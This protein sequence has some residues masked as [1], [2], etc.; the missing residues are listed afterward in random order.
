[1]PN[2]M[3]LPS[4]TSNNSNYESLDLAV[5]KIDLI[6]RQSING[7]IVIF[8]NAAA[9]LYISWNNVSHA[10]SI[11]WVSV[12]FTS[13]LIRLSMLYRWN[14]VKPTLRHMDETHFWHRTM[15]GLLLISGLC[16][17]AVGLVAPFGS[18][19]QQI[20]TA[21]LVCSMSAGAMITYVSSRVAM[22]C[23]VAPAMLGWG[24]GYVTS[25]QPHHLLVGMLVMVYC[26]LMIVMGKNLNQAI[27]KLLTLD[28]K[29]QKNEEHLRMS[30]ASSDALTW[31]WDMTTDSLHC[32]GNA[33]LFPLG[34]QQLKT[35]LKENRSATPELYTEAIFTDS[36]GSARHVALKGRF[37]RN[38][39]N[40]PYRAT[41]IAWDI[42]T[43]RN[44]E[45][46][47]R[48]R[49]LHEAANNAKSVLLANASHEIRTPLAAILGFADTLL[50]NPHL[51]DQS[52]RDVQSIHRQGNF[53]ASLVNDLLDLS[54]IETN[55]LYIQKAPMN[56]AR[57]LEDSLSVIRSALEDQKHDIQIYYES[58]IPEIIES[59]SVRFRQVLINLLSN[60]V[61]FTQEGTIT[62]RVAFFSDTDNNGHLTIG[63]TDTG[64]GM[65]ESTQKNLFQPFVRGESAEVQRVQGSGLGLALS[66]R[67]ARMMNGRLHLV[68]SELGK[69]STFELSLNVG[70]VKELKLVAPS[71]QKT[72]ALDRVKIAKETGFL[73]DRR[74]LVVDDSEDL[75]LLMNRYLKKQGAD[76]D[77]AENGEEAVTKAMARPFDVILMDIKMPIMDGYKATT[78][79]RTKG[80]TRPIV[81][82]TAQ[83]SVEGQKKSMEYG[84]DGY[85]SKP[86]DM[87]LLN[88]ILTR[89]QG[90]LN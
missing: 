44:E 16:W 76:V 1:M 50:R 59:D 56:P 13:V 58:Q 9:F 30:M 62:V 24:I 52:R 80:Y 73:K 65:D 3:D 28:T 35:L 7:V 55:R 61:K 84:F 57:E 8:A 27:I 85:L 75:R 40:V 26:G 38:P 46:L 89:V 71:Q 72:Q 67:L 83:A 18:T 69:G 31:D 34:T 78:Q 37:Y 14:R 51:D 36:F 17:A 74:V 42:T 43:K 41:G 86:V 33:D 53:M 12:L 25:G 20:L 21:L 63:V 2:K 39:D 60:A 4:L 45:L 22:M 47:R 48:E 88:D 81:A 11:T 79:L 66:E 87:T 5:R 23:V 68:T 54:K 10:F 49:D 29:L 19:T 6:Y 82:L 32:E 64:M 77:T 90:P 15:C 70:P